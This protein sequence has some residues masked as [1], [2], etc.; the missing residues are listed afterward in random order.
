MRNTD[1]LYFA[2]GEGKIVHLLT[3]GNMIIIL[4]ITNAFTLQP[5]I[6]SLRIYPTDIFAFVLLT[7]II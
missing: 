1:L 5:T 2:A 7:E 3:K 6:L 4:I